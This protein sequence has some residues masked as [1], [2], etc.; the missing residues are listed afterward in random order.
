MGAFDRERATREGARR[1]GVW[2]GLRSLVAAALVLWSL[3]V[4]AVAFGQRQLVFLPTRLADVAGALEAWNVAGEYVGVAHEV[5]RPTS[6]WLVLH[7]NAGQAGQRAY[8]RGVL[9]P[10][11]ALYVLEYPG[12]G[13]RPGEPSRA[14]FDAAARQAYDALVARFEGVPI[15]VLGESLGSGPAASLARATPPPAAIVLAVPFDRLADVAAEAF[16][17]LPARLLLW[18]RWDNGAALADYRGPLVV[19]A[20]EHDVVVPPHHARALAARVPGARLELLPCGHDDWSRH[21]PRGLLGELVSS[22]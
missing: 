19:L 8:L 15:G 6:V 11:A 4:V 1:A 2:R 9:P 3:F 16:W 10:G 18:D 22:H 17:W 7:G 13:P 21:V 14:S 12:Y 5:E 20:A